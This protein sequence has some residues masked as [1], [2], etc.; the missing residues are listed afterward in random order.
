MKLKT[1]SNPSKDVLNQ[2]T[3]SGNYENLFD[4]YES[5]KE[6]VRSGDFGKTPKFWMDYMDKI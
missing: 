1:F 4:L 2:A 3:G 5:V 6:K